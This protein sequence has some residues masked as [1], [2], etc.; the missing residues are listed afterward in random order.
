[1]TALGHAARFHDK[2][3]TRTQS[4]APGRGPDAGSSP[5]SP[6]ACSAGHQIVIDDS[7]VGKKFMLQATGAFLGIAAVV[8]VGLAVMPKAD[9]GGTWRNAFALHVNQNP[10]HSLKIGAVSLGLKPESIYALPTRPYFGRTGDGRITAEFAMD[11][12]EYTIWFTPDREGRRAQRIRFAKTFDGVTAED[13]LKTQFSSFG[14]PVET[15]CGRL[16]A[17]LGRKHCRYTWNRPDGTTATLSL[18]SVAPAIGATRTE[19]MLSLSAP[20]K[21]VAQPQRR[22]TAGTSL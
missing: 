1:M 18:R 5:H 6:M 11:G 4:H 14:S 3:N 2:I 9:D 8:G 7:T 17:Y 22:G 21:V 19:M 20:P 12:G 16:L 13:V 10:V 15:E